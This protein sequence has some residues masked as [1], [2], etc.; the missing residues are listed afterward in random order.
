LDLE[1]YWINKIKTPYIGDDGAIV[2]EKIY[3]MDAFW[4]GT[5][6]KKKWMSIE[7]IAYK[8]FMVN[9]SDMVAMNATTK[10]MLITVAFPKNIK[11]KIIK[12]L[13]CSFTN[14]ANDHNIQII[15]GDT[16]GSNK[17]G[18]VITMIG[19]SKNPLRR[20]TLNEGDLIAYT[21]ELGESKRDLERLLDG[22]RIPDNSKFYRPVLRADFIKAVTPWLSAGMDISD[23]LYCDTNKLLKVN[24]LYMQELKV[25]PPEIGESGEEYE[26]LIA[27]DPKNLSRVKRIAKLTDTPLTIFG[28]ATK[29]K[30]EKF[31]CLSQHFAKK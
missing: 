7:Q 25:I 14:L 5:H 27:F 15:G 28:K 23:G 2:Q 18:I 20:D 11:K 17:L 10:Y 26:M 19:E 9:L 4:E 13:S 8:A 31:P 1:S 6:F 29:E 16:I 21:G 3:A 24:N 12:R 30:I 22:E